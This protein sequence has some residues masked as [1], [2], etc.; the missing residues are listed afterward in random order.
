MTRRPLRTLLLLAL[1]TPSACEVPRFQGP[2]IQNPPLGFLL[3]PD[4]HP[5]TR[6]FPGR[7]VI[8]HSAWVRTD[9]SGVSLIFVDGHPGD[10]SLE[11]VLTAVEETRQAQEDPDTHYGNVEALRID[12]RD[13]W[14]WYER[15]ESP[16]RGLV[17]VV[18]KAV[19]PYDTVTYAIEFTSGDPVFK[20]AAP[21]TLRTVVA[22]FGVGRTVWNL[23][24]IAI[25]TGAL[26]LVVSTVRTRAQERAARLR[27]INLVKIEKKQENDA[28]PAGTAAPVTTPAPAGPPPDP[29]T[30]SAPRPSGSARGAE[31]GS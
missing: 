25:M 11:E 3:Q 29:A 10:T 28:E 14:G 21:D 4:N 19:V 26:L 27:S 1:V 8:F 13:G 30:T 9:L 23:P 22:S 17:H 24:L 18:Y 16:S 7:D 15:I 5:P 2:Q 20:R 12:G 6:I 31:P